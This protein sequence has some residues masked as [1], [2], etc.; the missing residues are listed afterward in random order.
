MSS[1]NVTCL[2]A[3]FIKK[4]PKTRNRESYIFKLILFVCLCELIEELR[5]SRSTL[6]PE[7]VLT[8]FY[9]IPIFN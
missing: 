6:Y 7:Y 1:S 4:L 3:A 2:L 9:Y 8:E 5:G